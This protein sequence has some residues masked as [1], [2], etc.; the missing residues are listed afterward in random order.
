[1]ASVHAG[2]GTKCTTVLTLLSINK[3]A[4]LLASK[5]EAIA[6]F[7]IIENKLW[8]L[9]LYGFSFQVPHCLIWM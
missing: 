5:L 3:N 4:I 9:E 8:A 2:H 6:E 7:G 1:M